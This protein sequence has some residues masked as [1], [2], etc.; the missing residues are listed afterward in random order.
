MDALN[1]RVWAEM[2]EELFGRSLGRI[3]NRTA[4]FFIILGA[5]GFGGQL[6]FKNFVGEVLWPFSTTLFGSDSGITLDNI[7]SV[8]IVL[9]AAVA[10]FV[11]VFSAFV[12]FAM[13]TFRRRVI[14]QPVIDQ[15]AELRSRGISILNDRP[16]NPADDFQRWQDVWRE[17][18]NEVVDFLRHNLTTAETLAFDRLGLLPELPWG[19]LPIDA[20]HAH[21]LNMLAKE[22]TILE[23][24]IQ[25]HQE[26]H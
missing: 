9:V 10:F 25:V 4:L 23:N 13:R 5:V 15:L 22:L 8:I 21:H 3:L 6:F 7:E 1:P 26:R 11:I 14:P 16:T 18:R 20:V 19:T 24:L 12:L 17:W 2:V